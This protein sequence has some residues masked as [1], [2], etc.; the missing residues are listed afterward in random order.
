MALPP[1]SPTAAVVGPDPV[2]RRL[3]SFGPFGISISRARPSVWTKSMRNTIEVVLTNQR[4]CGVWNPRF[5]AFAFGRKKGQV[6]FSIPLAS[7]VVLEL[8][9]LLAA[10]V[11]YVQYREG[12]ESKELC[13][14]AALGL[15][16]Y[17]E[18]LYQQLRELEVTT[19]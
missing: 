18:Q 9:N 2:E 15:H 11:L 6:Y 8:T 12:A 7:I 1:I 14:E 13:V 19:S 5:F 4:L 17:V 16:Q 10:R 3:F